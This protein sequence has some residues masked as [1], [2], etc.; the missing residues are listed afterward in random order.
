MLCCA[1]QAAK[2]KKGRKMVD[3]EDTIK[4]ETVIFFL[5]FY[6]FPFFF[7]FRFSLGKDNRLVKETVKL[8]KELYVSYF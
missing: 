5:F 7:F 2:I 4:A 6:F 3:W 8:L 1:W